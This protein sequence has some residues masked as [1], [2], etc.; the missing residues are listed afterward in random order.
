MRLTKT[1]SQTV[2]LGLVLALGGSSTVPAAATACSFE[3]YES[4]ST[5]PASNATGVPLNA[6]IR[7]RDLVLDRTS[8]VAEIVPVG[9]AGVELTLLRDEES[10][11]FLGTLGTPLAGDTVY[12]LRFAWELYCEF[13]LGDFRCD[14]EPPV[15]GSIVIASFRTGTGTDQQSPVIGSGAA[16]LTF[17]TSDVCDDSACCGPYDQRLIL[18]DS[19][20]W[21]AADDAGIAGYH[22]YRDG[23]LVAGYLPA[24]FAFPY[25]PRQTCSGRVQGLPGSLRTLSLDPGTYHVVAE[26]Y[27]GNLS[28]P[29]QP[30]VLGDGCTGPVDAGMPPSSAR[31]GCGVQVSGTR[32]FPF[33]VMLAIVGLMVGRR[34]RLGSTRERRH[35]AEAA[36][37]S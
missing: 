31:S 27:L 34:R 17:G 37:R 23:E 26:D 2:R 30:V 10:P 36:G 9:G 11:Y 16:S 8:V 20:G 6:T 15:G 1:L 21:A 4:I 29:S 14:D 13:M 7:V 35:A 5:V 3:Q 12:E 25:G 32:R 18:A 28:E 22:L 33:M 19:S 24:P